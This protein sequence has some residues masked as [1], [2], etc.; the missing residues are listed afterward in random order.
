M[1]GPRD[2]RPHIII[3]SNDRCPHILQRESLKPKPISKSM[4]DKLTQLPHESIEKVSHHHHAVDDDVAAA[5]AVAVTVD[6]LPL[7]FIVS[8]KAMLQQQQQQQQPGSQ[9]K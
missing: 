6:C 1:I 2:G 4:P 5:V 7:Y 8:P 9:V 3:N